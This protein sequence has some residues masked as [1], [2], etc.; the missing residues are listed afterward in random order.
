MGAYRDESGNGTWFAKFTYTN[1][2]GEKINKKKR[3]FK[4]KKAALKWEGDFLREQSGNLDMSFQ[5]F[6]KVY[7]KDMRPRLRENTWKTKEQIIVTKVIPY[8]GDLPVNEI[9]KT[10]IV[11]WQNELM[12][13]EN[14]K[15]EKYSQTYLRTIHA[16]LS[17]IL[18]HACKYYNLR[19]NVAREVGSIGK[20]E[21]SEMKFWTESEYDK[22]IEEVKDK[23]LSFYAFEILYWCGLRTGELLALTKE[24][25]DFTNNTIRVNQSLQRIS[26]RN[27]ITEP[28]TQKSIRT[29]VM[30]AF[31]AEEM[32]KYM[33]GIYK[34]KDNQLLFP[35]TKSYLH[36]E[37]TRGSTKA[38]VKRIR[39]H[40]L[41]HSHVSLL[42]ELGYSAIAIADRLGHESIDITYRYAHLFPS[43]Q[44]DMAISLSNIRK[45]NL[46]DQWE[47]LLEDEDDLQNEEII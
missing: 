24:K 35:I 7:E 10:T 31:L 15:G 45:E 14:S 20:K 28:K 25:F 40:D 22:F 43:K 47:K 1:W 13:E 21:A 8:I 44:N 5:D 46:D 30:P 11:K 27:I 3:G 12:K 36:H 9:S 4:T 16:Q 23:P 18:N 34:L 19:S 29:V 2:R 39:V 17:S 42:I 33:A 26:G 37:M 38:G 41:R 32:K 6:F